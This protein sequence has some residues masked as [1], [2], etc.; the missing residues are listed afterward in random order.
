MVLKLIPNSFAKGMY[1]FFINK[2]LCIF[3]DLAVTMNDLAIR[4]DLLCNVH[5]VHCQ[6][7]MGIEMGRTIFPAI[8]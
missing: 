6:M 2:G 8:I 4:V 1:A 3:R 7:Q 5:I